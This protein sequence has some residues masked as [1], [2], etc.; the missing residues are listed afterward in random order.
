M[1]LRARRG[2]TEL[3]CAKLQLGIDR[4]FRPVRGVCVLARA[5]F[6]AFVLDR[7]FDDGVLPSVF[8]R[9]LLLGVLHDMF[10]SVLLDAFDSMLFDAHRL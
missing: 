4:W 7:L 5:C 8:D 3:A 10:D 9:V 1:H 2:R 6:D